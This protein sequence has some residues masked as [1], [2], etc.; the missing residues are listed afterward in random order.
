MEAARRLVSKSLKAVFA[1][2]CILFLLLFM[3]DIYL[4]FEFGA[5]AKE[6]MIFD[7]TL[8]LV[9]CILFGILAELMSRLGGGP[10][11]ACTRARQVL[12]FQELVK[13]AFTEVDPAHYTTRNEYENAV[14]E[15]LNQLKARSTEI[16]PEAKKA[17]KPHSAMGTWEPCRIGPGGIGEEYREDWEKYE[18]PLSEIEFENWIREKYYRKRG[19]PDIVWEAAR[20]HEE[21][22]IKTCR[23]LKSRG[24]SYNVYMQEPR[25]YQ[26]D[27]LKAYD[28]SI[29]ILKEWIDNNCR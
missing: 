27:E 25:G 23:E 10:S 15:R 22:H 14:A 5:E 4:I 3:Y 19:E 21:E 2:L 8:A 24:K 1:A 9:L 28:A 16:R 12:A 18:I 7:P 17:G 29:K 11:S 20:A 26:A 6:H 13:Q